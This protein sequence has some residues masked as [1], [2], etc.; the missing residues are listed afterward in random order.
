M[1]FKVFKVF[2]NFI[3]NYFLEVVFVQDAYYV[4]TENFLECLVF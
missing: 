1:T 4:Q 2:Q 3:P